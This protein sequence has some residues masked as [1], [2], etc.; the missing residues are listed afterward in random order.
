MSLRR[1]LCAWLCCAAVPSFAHDTWVETNTNVV[2][3]GDTIAIDLKLGNHGND[4]R[5]F[6]L[7]SK[8]D[9]RFC[10]LEVVAPDGKRYNLK[11]RLIDTGYTPTEGFWRARFAGTTPGLYLVAQTHDQV[12]SYAPVRSIKSGKTCYVVSDSLDRVSESNP[13]FDRA[14]GHELELVPLA[15]PVTPMGIGR[16]FEVRLLFRGK[17]LADARVSFIPQGKELRESFDS[18]YERTTDAEGRAAFEPREANL[19]LIVAHHQDPNAA[20]EGYAS[21]KYS[22]TLTVLVPGVC[23]C[24][25][26]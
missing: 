15:N 16:Q 3:T 22:A 17:P 19:F 23:P 18:D 12:M 2:R 7:A 25:L 4:H 13:G 11:E 10:T 24:C 20:G 26:E 8:V 1:L 14:L 6:K 21:T 5:D 9:P